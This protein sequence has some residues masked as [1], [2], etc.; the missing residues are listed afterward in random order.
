[1]YYFIKCWYENL[2]LAEDLTELDNTNQRFLTICNTK[3][4]TTKQKLRSI[5]RKLYKIKY[6]IGYRK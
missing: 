5:K 3:D 4:E 6:E 2:F 1:M